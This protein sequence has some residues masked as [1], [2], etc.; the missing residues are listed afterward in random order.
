MRLPL[1]AV[2][3]ICDA[4][5]IQAIFGFCFTYLHLQCLYSATH[6]ITTSQNHTTTATT[7][8]CSVLS[9]IIITHITG[10]LPRCCGV[11]EVRFF[12]AILLYHK[13]TLYCGQTDATTTKPSHQHYI[14]AYLL[15]GCILTMYFL[16]CDDVN[17]YYVTLCVIVSFCNV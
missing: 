10:I 5:F 12:I 7:I 11:I 3:V 15:R 8:L 4:F 13:F 2:G 1:A 14:I 6:L 17:S 16:S 9:V